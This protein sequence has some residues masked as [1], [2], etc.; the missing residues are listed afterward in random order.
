[1]STVPNP[2]PSRGRAHIVLIPGFAGFDA[3]GQIE[4]YA[5]TT[6]SYQRWRNA[7]GSP[8]RDVVLHY[9]DNL[10]TAGV[11]TRA[12]RLR[13]YLAKRIARGE[14]QDGDTIALVGHSTGGL[15]IR[16]MLSAPAP[17]PLPLDGGGATDR[18]KATVVNVHQSEILDRVSRVVFVSV[19]QFGTNIADW[20]RGHT[21]LRRSVIEGLYRGVQG[22]V[23]PP[24]E[25]AISGLL[26]DLGK[27][28]K[29]PDLIKAAQDALSETIASR[30]DPW[31][32]ANAQEAASQLRLWLRHAAD[33]F[34]AIDDLA[35][36]TKPPLNSRS[37]AHYSDDER[38]AECFQWRHNGIRTMSIATIGRRAFTFDPGKPA[39]PFDFLKESTWPTNEQASDADQMDIS[40]LCAYRACAGGWF[41]VPPSLATVCRDIATLNTSLFDLTKLGPHGPKPGEGL[42]VWDNDGIVNT[43]SMLWPNREDTLLVAADHLDIVGHYVARKTVPSPD[44]SGRH[45]AS[46]DGLKSHTSFTQDEFDHVWNGIFDFCVR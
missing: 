33:D 25:K 27:L 45:Y 19:P 18:S 10:P 37:P 8:D 36:F 32:R 43:A 4:Y 30:V 26:A 5:G 35:S 16:R 21:L 38:Q 2:S 15:D 28:A 9:F 11:Q 34:A 42:A 12:E 39:E 13:G 24:L 23:I 1:M 40:Y 17:D 3:L 6:D 14:I 7:G 31:Q 44:A 29:R 20:V 41:E 22:A 46:Y